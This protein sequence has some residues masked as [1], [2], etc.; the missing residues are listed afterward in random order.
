MSPRPNVR[1]GLLTVLGVSAVVGA[2]GLVIT[3]GFFLHGTWLLSSTNLGQ[4]RTS[5]ADSCADCR[6][7]ETEIDSIDWGGTA[8]TRSVAE[9]SGG[10]QLEVEVELAGGD[11]HPAYNQLVAHIVAAG[12]PVAASLGRVDGSEVVSTTFVFDAP[13]DTIQ[14]EL[15]GD[16]V[17]ISAWVS[18]DRMP[19]VTLGNMLDE[20][21]PPSSDMLAVDDLLRCE[22]EGILNALLSI[23]WPPTTDIVVT[24][25]R[26]SRDFL[27]VNIHVQDLEGLLSDQFAVALFAE[28]GWES[29]NDSP[30]GSTAYISTSGPLAEETAGITV[31]RSESNVRLFVGYHSPALAEYQ[32]PPLVEALK[33][34]LAQP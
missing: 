14:I 33:A 32:T 20:I 23:D 10:I 17:H 16:T 19:E 2:I 8:T 28:L 15:A 12:R 11:G 1:R 31:D 22:C 21:G 5:P 13:D 30:L 3:V 26:L 7:L 18:D 27:S 29:R 9:Q 4:P 25:D 34:A 24:R 6:S